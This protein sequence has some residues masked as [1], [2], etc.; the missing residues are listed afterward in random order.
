LAADRES[1]K[2]AQETFESQEA[3]YRLIERRYRVGASASLTC[4]QAQTRVEAARR[5]IAIFTS[6]I[7]QDE[8]ALAL[9]VGATGSSGAAAWP[10]G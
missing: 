6:R 5:N 10:D 2:L 8:N 4:G 7:A 9:L 3:S 1:L